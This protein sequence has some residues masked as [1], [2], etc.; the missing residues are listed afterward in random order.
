MADRS[1]TFLKSLV[2]LGRREKDRVVQML[3]EAGHRLRSGGVS[4]A[5]EQFEN[6]RF[7]HASL[8]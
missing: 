7:G 1:R 5:R 2:E 8:S 3:G 4:H 6:P